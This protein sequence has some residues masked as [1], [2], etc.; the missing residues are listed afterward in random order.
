MGKN[1]SEVDKKEQANQKAESNNHYHF[2]VCEFAENDFIDKN[3]ILTN[4]YKENIDE[5][6]FC[7]AFYKLKPKQQKLLLAS[8]YYG[9]SVKGIASKE[10]VLSSATSQ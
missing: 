4:L 10:D 8:C 1:L 9:V 2:E 3:D 7:F 6:K 5:E